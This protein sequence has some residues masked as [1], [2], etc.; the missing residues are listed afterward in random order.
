MS[1]EKKPTDQTP[2]KFKK[3][4]TGAPYRG[5]P[6]DSPIGTTRDPANRKKHGPRKRTARD[7]DFDVLED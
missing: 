5:V 1:D 7:T 3:V 4:D 2:A 6:V